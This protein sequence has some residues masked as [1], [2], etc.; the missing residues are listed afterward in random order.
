MKISMK[1]LLYL[2]AIALIPVFTACNEDEDGNGT[3]EKPGHDIAATDGKVTTLQTAT[4]GNGINI[5]LMGDGFTAEDIEAGT[6]DEIMRK[7]MEA[8]FITQPIKGMR[9]YFNVYAVQKVSLSS[10][11]NGQTALGTMVNGDLITGPNDA[12]A[13]DKRSKTVLYASAVPGYDESRTFIGV[14]INDPENSAGITSYPNGYSTMACAYATLKGTVDS[15]E[16]RQLFTHELVGHGIGKLADEYVPRG[17]T[18]SNSTVDGYSAGQNIYGW[19]QN[20]SLV[21]RLN[22]SPWNYI[23]ADERYT[24]ENLTCEPIAESED[25]RIVYSATTS[26]I[27]SDTTTPG[28]GFNAPSR[29]AIYKNIMLLATGNEPTYEDFVAYDLTN[30]Q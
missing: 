3:S 28:M 7:A 20:I 24:D 25:G 2:L 23:A 27:M 1:Y 17:G 4:E 15:D 22:R 14:V 6:Y 11:L 19:Y 16:F 30:R 26:S 12:E 8:L 21:A 10:I 5:I 29:F 9:Q 13:Y 18:Y